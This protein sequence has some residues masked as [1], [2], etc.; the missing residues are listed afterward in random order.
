[1]DKDLEL[2][3]RQAVVAEALGWIGT[4]YHT[5]ARVKHHGADCLT[6]VVQVYENV[7]LIPPYKIPHY[8][9]DWHLHSDDERYMNGVR[10]FCDEVPGPPL[11]ADVVLFRFGRSYSHGAIV[12]EWPRIIHAYVRKKVGE[13]NM[14]N[15]L[16]LKYIGENVSERGR[17]RPLRFF[18][19]RSWM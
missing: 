1:M 4:P 14:D 9:Q 5:G 18:R 13:E 10:E 2:R 19:L 3:Q 6:F 11:P 15:A 12:I 17:V 7:G 16:W 8:P